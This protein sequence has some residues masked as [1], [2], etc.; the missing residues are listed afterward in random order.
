MLQH[1]NQG[2]KEVS[3][4]LDSGRAWE[5]LQL[6][7]LF[8]LGFHTLTA[9]ERSL[10]APQRDRAQPFP[11]TATLPWELLR[12]AGDSPGTGLAQCW[13]LQDFCCCLLRYLPSEPTC[14]AVM[15]RLSYTLP[16]HVQR[17]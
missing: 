11:T 10:P 3:E 17:P 15:L 7:L 14:P 6:E 9:A 1:A 5:I 4:E 12:I 13:S 2:L 16:S 8:F